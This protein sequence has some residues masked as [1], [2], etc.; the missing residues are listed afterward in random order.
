VKNIDADKHDDGAQLW[1]IKW[2]DD[3]QS[4]YTF[5]ECGRQSSGTPASFIMRPITLAHE[6]ALRPQHLSPSCLL[7][8]R[9]LTNK[10]S[11]SC[12]IIS[13][14]RTYKYSR[15]AQQVAGAV[16]VAGTVIQSV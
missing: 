4:D 3:T 6:S 5:A 2:D 14:A 15:D 10:A 12:G 13:D 8:G 7:S 1:G 9:E 16:A 11:S